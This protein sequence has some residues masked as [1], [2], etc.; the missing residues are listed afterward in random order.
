[1]KLL[2]A[3]I[4][5]TASLAALIFVVFSSNTIP[6]NKTEYTKVAGVNTIIKSYPTSHQIQKS[7]PVVNRVTTDPDPV[8]NCKLSQYCSYQVITTKKSECDQISCCQ[9]GNTW[10]VHPNKTSCINA[11]NNYD[12]E[13]Y[14][15]Y[16]KAEPV[17][18]DPIVVVTPQPTLKPY[19]YSSEFVG[20][21]NQFYQNLNEEFTPTQL[22]QPVTRCYTTWEEYFTAHPNYAPQNIQGGTPPCD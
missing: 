20:S 3:I 21:V 12:R 9:V 18:F 10:S 14:T 5:C 15:S 16:E 6:L 19:Q 8:V 7:Q 1:M 22:T 2:S 4:F 13:Q 17:K 11:Q